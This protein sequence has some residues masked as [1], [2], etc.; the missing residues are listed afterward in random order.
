MILDIFLAFIVCGILCLMSQII[1]DNTK[2]TTGHITSLFVVIGSILEFLNIYEYVR[3]IGKMGASLPI[4][5][6]GSIIMKGVKN[7]VDENGFLGI[8]TGVFENCGTLLALAIFLAF[9]S[10]IFFKPKS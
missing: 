2:L 7:G 6:F 10:T 3:K 9:L 8:F 5:S 4:C 1:L